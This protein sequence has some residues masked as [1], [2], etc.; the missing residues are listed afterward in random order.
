LAKKAKTSAARQRPVYIVAEIL[1]AEN[2]DHARTA[3]ADEV[4]ETTR[5]GFSLLAHSVT[6][7]GSGAVMS[8]VVSAGA[9]SLFVGRWPEELGDPAS[10]ADLATWLKEE[11]RGLLLGV[12]DPVSDRDRL[13][14]PDDLP[15]TRDM[16][17]IYLAE[18]PVL[19]PI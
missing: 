18:K 17:A 14:P 13:N 16:L 11:R 8:R 10:F 12:R 1:D 6:T 7:P 4:I 9:H 19:E 15:V 3:G 5:L 2:V